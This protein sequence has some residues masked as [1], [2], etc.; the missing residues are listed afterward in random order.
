MHIANC[1]TVIS[2]PFV[3]TNPSFQTLDARFRTDPF[4]AP[5]LQLEVEV[6][7]EFAP[8]CSLT[9]ASFVRVVRV[10]AHGCMIYGFARIGAGTLHGLGRSEENLQILKV[11]DPAVDV[12]IKMDF[13]R[14]FS[15]AW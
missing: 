2:L 8:T 14:A 12:H 15:L 3:K 9:T 6:S 1:L 7:K 10:S 5:K 4:W 11:G 13:K